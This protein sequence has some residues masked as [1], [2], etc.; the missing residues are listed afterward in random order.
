[1][2]LYL[3]IFASDLDDEEID[4]VEVGAYDDFDLLRTTVAQQL[5]AGHWGSRFPVLMSHPDS[6]GEWSPKEAYTSQ[7]ASSLTLAA[8]PMKSFS[9]RPSS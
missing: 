3:C 4:G 2:G 9:E 8:A 6:D 5:E 7:A 1:M